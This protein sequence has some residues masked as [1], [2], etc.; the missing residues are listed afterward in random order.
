MNLGAVKWFDTALG[1]GYISP[2]DGTPDVFVHFTALDLAGL[3]SLSEGQRVAYALSRE[4][5]VPRA[6]KLSIAV[7]A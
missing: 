3:E 6:T 1:Y 7:A 4:G 2:A 5:R